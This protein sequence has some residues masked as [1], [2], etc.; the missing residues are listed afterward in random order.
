[1]TDDVMA[2]NE[3]ESAGGGLE[4]N[5]ERG[6]PSTLPAGTTC[7]PLI[8]GTCICPEAPDGVPEIGV[9]GHFRP[10]E[11]GRMPRL[12][13]GDANYR[14]GFWTN[15]E[16]E[17]GP[18]G[19]SNQVEFRVKRPDGSSITT[20]VSQIRSV[21]SAG[22]PGQEASPARVAIAMATYN[23]D[24]VLFTRQIES[25]REQSEPDWTCL[26]SD[27]CSDAESRSFIESA[28]EGDDRFHFSPSPERLGFYRNFER[29]LGMVPAG[30]GFI[31][32]C[33][34]DDSWHPDKLE[35]LIASIGDASLIYSDQRLVD[36]DGNLISETFWVGRRNNFTDYRSM[37]VANT[38]TG[39]ASMFRAD[40]LDLLLPFPDPPGWQFHDQWIAAAAMATGD[41]A[42]VDRPLYDY[43]QHPGAILGQ[44]SGEETSPGVVSRL[45]ER[46]AE[47]RSF[48]TGWRAAYFYDYLRIQNQAELILFRGGARVRKDRHKVLKWFAEADDGWS[49]ALRLLLRPVRGLFGRNETLGVE[50]QL[51]RG[52]IWRRLVEVRSDR[53]KPPLRGGEPDA[54]L[55]VVA[56]TEYGSQRLRRWRSGR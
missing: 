32:L 13:I 21:D 33:D 56:P 39:A 19:E 8:V 47:W 24:P 37:L 14:S 26:I 44:V 11:N 7:V 18:A 55:P 42:Y 27:D 12:G 38:V 49:A 46:T 20:G 45:K 51:A 30:V 17:A 31:A 53:V 3:G 1:M 22:G 25:I 6:L 10:V 29:A 41:L 48:S 50:A 40:L 15:L 4:V 54:G 23:P 34:Q 43:V 35:T 9:N 2:Q 36:R 5:L 28:I 16:I 52:L